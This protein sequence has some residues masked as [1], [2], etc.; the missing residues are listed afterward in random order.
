MTNPN[1]DLSPHEQRVVAATLARIAAAPPRRAISEPWIDLR[2]WWRP[3]LAAAAVVMVV[4]GWSLIH[5]P[6]PRTATTVTEAL[7]LPAPI[8]RWI[9]TGDPTAWVQMASEGGPR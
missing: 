7:G 6:A 1:D 5:R 3:A 9:D 4:S 2:P 8:A